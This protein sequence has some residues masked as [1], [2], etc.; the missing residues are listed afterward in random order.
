MDCTAKQIKSTKGK[1]VFEI[2]TDEETIFESLY[3]AKAMAKKLKGKKIT[4][5]F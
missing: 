5:Q 3:V 1:E 4:I 2:V